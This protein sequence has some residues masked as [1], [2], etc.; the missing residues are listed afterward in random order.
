MAHEYLV[1]IIDDDE[2]AR[3]ALIILI[4]AAGFAV[5]SHA[6]ATDFLLAGVEAADG[7][8][9]AELCL[10]DMSGLHLLDRLQHSE[11]PMPVIF[12]TGHGDIKSAVA[13][14]RAGAIDFLEKPLLDDAVLAS[15]ERARAVQQLTL[16]EQE[17]RAAA[18]K[19]ILS[20]SAREQQVLAGVLA[21]LSN[22]IIAHQLGLSPRTIEVYRAS[23]MA[24]AHTKSLAH[25]FRVSN[26]YHVYPPL[27]FS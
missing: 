25:L 21:G 8:V 2:V 6:S 23:M 14:M 22:K 27:A 1:H 24:K 10:P 3:R 26:G 16:R 17:G 9:L 19:L 20:L 11:Q 4:S 15:I 13:V 12:V 7:C 5:R 18:R